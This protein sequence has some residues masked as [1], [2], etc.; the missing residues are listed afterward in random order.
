MFS[1]TAQQTQN[2]Y[3]WGQGYG[4]DSWSYENS[5]RPASQGGPAPIVPVSYG[6]PQEGPWSS[7][8]PILPV[9]ESAST[10]GGPAPIPVAPGSSQPGQAEQLLNS[11]S[12]KY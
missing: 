5:C 12:N 1:F 4:Q 11:V 9:F 3:E 2:H 10:Q 8:Q 6:N 7:R